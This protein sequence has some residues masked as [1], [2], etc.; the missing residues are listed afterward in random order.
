MLW[1]W[2]CVQ[3]QLFNK[4]SPLPARSPFHL[5]YKLR[6]PRDRAALVRAQSALLQVQ[7]GPAGLEAKVFLSCVPQLFSNCS[8]IVRILISFSAVARVGGRAGWRQC[9]GDR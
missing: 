4:D 6:S 9:Q 7:H 1:L 2:I 5:P 8:S 3:V